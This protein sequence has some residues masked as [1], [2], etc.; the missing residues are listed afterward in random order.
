LNIEEI[1]DHCLAKRGVTKGFPFGRSV[2]VYRL[3]NKMYALTDVDGN[4]PYSNLKCDPERAI[5]SGIRTRL[6]K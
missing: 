1:D 6:S 3:L 4:P 5:D 2:L